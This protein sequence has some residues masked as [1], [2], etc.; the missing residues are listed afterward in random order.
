MNYFA[1]AVWFLDGDPYFIAGTAVPDWL[2]VVDRRVRVRLRDALPVAEPEG[3][4]VGSVARGVV[5]HLR[6]DAQ[7]HR[8]AAFARLSLELT[9]MARLHL[10]GDDSLRPAFLGHLLVEVLL[11][12]ALVAGDPEQLRTYYELLGRVDA[13]QVQAAVNGMARKSTHLLGLL[14]RRFCEEQ[15]L[16]DYLDDE[17]LFLRLNQVM[18]RVGLLPLPHTLAAILPEA[19]AKVYAAVAELLQGIPSPGFRPQHQPQ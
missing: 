9:G 1:H 17:R 7:F 14:I 19:R 4:L 3:G 10:S 11:D 16:W 2:S 18:R 12:A 15:I 13:Q 8:T 5:Q 6:D